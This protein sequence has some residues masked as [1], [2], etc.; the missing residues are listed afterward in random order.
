MKR[1]RIGITGGIGSGKSYI[2]NLISN[3]YGI[4]LYNT[5]NIAK[6]IMKNNLII[7]Q[8]IINT[9][10]ED[11]YIDGNINKPKLNKILFEDEDKSNLNT[12]NSIIIP[13]IVNDFNDWCDKQDSSFVLFESAIIFETGIER[14]FDFIICVVADMNV[15]INR[16]SKRDNISK[17][18]IL[19]RINNQLTDEIKKTKSDFILP[20]NNDDD[21]FLSLM[22]LMLSLFKV[23]IK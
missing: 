22:P 21:I 11:S 3:I 12:M 6:D 13:A 23:I 5:D 10:G 15:R 14:N 16:V 17:D 18:L 19:N 8:K 4:P 20:N 1:I 7:K 2:S 9:F